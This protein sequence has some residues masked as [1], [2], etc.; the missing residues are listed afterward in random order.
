MNLAAH[1]YLVW[2][3]K[4]RSLLSYSST[5]PYIFITHNLRTI[6]TETSFQE[7]KRVCAKL[8]RHKCTPPPLSV[9]LLLI[10]HTYSAV[11][12]ATSGIRSSDLTWIDPSDGTLNVLKW[13]DSRQC[14]YFILRLQFRT[15]SRTHH[16]RK[17]K[18]TLPS[19]EK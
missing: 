4:L 10:R 8:H 18:G 16:S 15:G 9:C 1:F 13:F 5:L 11:S 6:K 17:E 14:E 3:L 2:E 19:K 7:T 12:R